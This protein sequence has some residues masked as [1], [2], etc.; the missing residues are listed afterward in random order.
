MELAIHYCLLD[1][2]KMTLSDKYTKSF[3]I[4]E[5]VPGYEKEPVLKATM[6]VEADGQIRVV[7][8]NAV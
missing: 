3:N 7:P 2:K 4:Y 5:I 6:Y 1:F 8:K